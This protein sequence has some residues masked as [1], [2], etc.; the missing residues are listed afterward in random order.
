M[1]GR[2]FSDICRELAVSAT[3]KGQGLLA[4]LLGVAA[5]EAAESGAR[6]D[7]SGVQDLLVGAWDWDVLNDCVY[8]DARFARLFGISAADAARGTALRAWVVAVHPDDR[9]HLEMEIKRALEG[10]LFSTEYRVILK[11]QTRWLYARGKCTLNKDGLAV[12]F[13]GAIV[14]I[15]HEKIDDQVSLAPL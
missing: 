7:D 6:H 8:A 5:L 11:G 9:D 4:Y 12:R 15:T 14:D 10:Q 1:S 2:L 13:P 3:Q